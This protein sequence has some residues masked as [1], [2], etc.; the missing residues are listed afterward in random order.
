MTSLSNERPKE[1]EWKNERL[2]ERMDDTMINERRWSGKK[3]RKKV[4]YT[5]EA[6]MLTSRRLHLATAEGL[7]R[8]DA[9]ELRQESRPAFARATRKS[10]NNVHM[11]KA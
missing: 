8:A 1:N 3:R 11:D 5:Y 6:M 7:D 4:R 10:I 2:V 9:R